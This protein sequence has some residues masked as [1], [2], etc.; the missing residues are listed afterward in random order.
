L[1]LA[2]AEAVIRRRC[3]LEEEQQG[4]LGDRDPLNEHAWKRSVTIL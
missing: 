4:G 1:I 2:A 3:I